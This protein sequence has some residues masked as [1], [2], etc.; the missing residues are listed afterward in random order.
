MLSG[1]ELPPSTG[2]K[3]VNSPTG[4]ADAGEANTRLPCHID[5]ASTRTKTV[6][7]FIVIFL[8]GESGCLTGPL[9][10]RTSRQNTGRS[11]P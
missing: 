8:I 10:D 2:A 4:A 7:S 9:W 5:P 6:R 11:L 1:S 3:V